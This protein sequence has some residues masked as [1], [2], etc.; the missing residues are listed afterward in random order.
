MF[1]RFRETASRLQVILVET[2]RVDGKVRYEHMASL[3]TIILS[4]S[5]ADRVAF[6]ARLHERL[7]KLANRIDAA[8][9]GKIM[10]NIHARVP[11]PT[12]DEQRTLQLENAKA[13]AEQWSAFRDLNAS[14]AADR[15]RLVATVEA[16][17]ADD[18]AAVVEADDATRKAQRRIE[19]I[20]RG[21]VVDGG[22]SKPGDVVAFLKK[23]GWTEADLRH[24]RL[25]GSM[26]L[27]RFEEFIEILVGLQI[28]NERR[29]SKR[30]VLTILC[31]YGD[32]RSGGSA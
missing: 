3:G 13:D 19:A 20:E 15:E 9:Q 22:L 23:D 18:K 25:L 7:A 10:G 21:E 11:M 28:K 27:E 4:P 32:G 17:I 12:P 6:W 26:P 2:R 16:Q 29:L 31:K 1:V 8:A 14:Q 24:A 5:V 30:A